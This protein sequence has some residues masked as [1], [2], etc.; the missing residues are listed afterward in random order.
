MPSR[1]FR[2]HNPGNLRYGAFARR[3]GAREQDEQGFARFPSTR[4]G[5]LALVD[6][7]FTRTYGRL[8]LAR[9]LERYAPA[10]ENPTQSYLRFVSSKSGVGPDEV[11]D[12]LSPAQHLRIAAA[13]SEFE[14]WRP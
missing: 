12:R 14:G 6:L 9:A 8:S 3:W 1:A 4:R 5:T 7:L 13:I 10:Q 11:L 2:N